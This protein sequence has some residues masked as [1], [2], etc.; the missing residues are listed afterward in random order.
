MVPA[1]GQIRPV[2]RWVGERAIC[3]M[4]VLTLVVLDWAGPVVLPLKGLGC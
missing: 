1:A 2:A 3:S 4:R